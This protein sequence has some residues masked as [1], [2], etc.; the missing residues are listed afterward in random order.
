M[1]DEYRQKITTALEK[2]NGI[3]TW[4]TR[5]RRFIRVEKVNYFEK[6]VNGGRIDFG[7]EVVEVGKRGQRNF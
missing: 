7:S 2:A 6:T 1:K 3:T 5:I 4:F